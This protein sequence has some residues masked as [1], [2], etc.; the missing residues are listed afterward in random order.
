[1]KVFIAVHCDVITTGTEYA[2]KIVSKNAPNVNPK[3]LLDVYG[4]YT[5]VSPQPQVEREET[6]EREV[7]DGGGEGLRARGRESMSEQEQLLS[8]ESSDSTTLS[9]SNEDS[10]TEE[11]SFLYKVISTI[12]KSRFVHS[13]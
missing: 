13:R 2:A 9:S 3:D 7:V 1:L 11:D 8:P 10:S 6:N 4:A 12:K 5:M